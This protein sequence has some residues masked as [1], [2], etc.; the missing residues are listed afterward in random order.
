MAVVLDLQ[1]LVVYIMEQLSELVLWVRV[2]P[3]V[4]P[5]VF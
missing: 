1:V 4:L 2:R 5:L 3:L